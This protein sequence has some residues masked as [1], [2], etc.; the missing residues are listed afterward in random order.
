MSGCQA[1]LLARALLACLVLSTVPA[2]SA[3]TTC[4]SA[5]KGCVTSAAFTSHAC[6]RNCTRLPDV[7]AA[8][9]RALDLR[10]RPLR[11]FVGRPGAAVTVTQTR[12][13]FQF[14]F[15]VD[16]REFANAPEDLAF[17]ESIATP[18]TNFVV[19]ETSLK[20]RVVEP[21]D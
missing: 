2:W 9:A 1:M 16:F 19:A 5:R 17:Y 11:L 6:E 18:H 8:D 13:A 12:H 10:S 15:P 20:W 7:A 14:G 3:N 21:T 4:V